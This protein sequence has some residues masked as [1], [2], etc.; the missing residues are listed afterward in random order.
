[1]KLKMTSLL[2]LG[3]PVV[4]FAQNTCATAQAVA[5][6]TYSVAAVD[7]TDV[8]S[9]IC[10]QNG[11]GATAGEWYTYTPTNDYSLTITTDLPGT[12]GND[13]RVHVYTGTCGALVC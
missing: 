4:N 9:V 2:L 10:A 1:M 11:I 13:T 8:P 7:G 3:F 5:V 12:A 6:G